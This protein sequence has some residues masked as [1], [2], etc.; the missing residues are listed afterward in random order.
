MPAVVAGVLPAVLAVANPGAAVGQ[1]LGSALKGGAGAQSAQQNPGGS[2]T[3]SA[4]AASSLPQQTALDTACTA[5]S[6]LLPF[7]NSFYA[8]LGGD[9]DKIDWTKFAEADAGKAADGTKPKNDQG[10]S[11][12][13]GNLNGQKSRFESTS[14]VA[15]QKVEVAY[16]KAIA[17]STAQQIQARL[18][19]WVVGHGGNPDSPEEEN[20]H[21]L[22]GSKRR[23]AQQLED[24]RQGC[25]RDVPV[26]FGDHDSEWVSERT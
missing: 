3:S 16:R 5:A 10:V 21:E 23:C 17:V 12:L 20:G 24:R 25:T 2:D 19:R 18:L 1:A 11:W 22:G 7:L 8:F 26:P 14:S 4:H 13:K 15:S 9:K 6:E